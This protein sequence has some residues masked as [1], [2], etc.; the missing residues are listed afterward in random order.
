MNTDL[1]SVMSFTETGFF[2]SLEILKEACAQGIPE[3]L[4]RGEL[5]RCG[6]VGG[7]GGGD[8]GANASG[9]SYPWL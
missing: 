6:G 8:G 3:T 5:N 2:F 4:C 1:E 9:P 7:G